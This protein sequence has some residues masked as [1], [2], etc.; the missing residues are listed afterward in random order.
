MDKRIRKILKSKCLHKRLK[1]V[2]SDKESVDFILVENPKCL[3]LSAMYQMQ[4]FYE[5]VNNDSIPW[6]HIYRVTIFQ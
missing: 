4:D 6:Y 2:T 3:R 5:L 1:P